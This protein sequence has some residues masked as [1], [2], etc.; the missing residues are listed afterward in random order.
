MLNDYRARQPSMPIF[1]PHGKR[2]DQLH[3]LVHSKGL[4][5]DSPHII[6]EKQKDGRVRLLLHPDLEQRI[7]T[8]EKAIA[9]L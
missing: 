3:E 4:V 2:L 1:G 5:I 9:A 8:L 7:A 6:A